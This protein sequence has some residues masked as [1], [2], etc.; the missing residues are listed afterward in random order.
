[1]RS[2]PTAGQAAHAD[3]AARCKRKKRLSGRL[4]STD[5]LGFAQA[6]HGFEPIKA[7]LD[8]L[9]VPLTDSVALMASGATIYRTTPAWSMDKR[10]SNG[11]HDNSHER[12]HNKGWQV[13][14]FNLRHGSG[15]DRSMERW[16]FSRVEVRNA[17][18]IG[19]AYQRE[20]FIHR[21]LSSKCTVLA[22]AI[23]P[24]PFQIVFVLCHD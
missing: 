7:F 4:G 23:I 13:W 24:S 8:P 6:T 21:V 1:M 18:C 15:T 10:R 3:Q 12:H 16:K 22:A 14:S 19:L 20:S 11:A 9:A 2:A 17:R 5:Q